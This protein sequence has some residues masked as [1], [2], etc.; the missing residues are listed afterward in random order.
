VFVHDDHQFVIGCLARSGGLARPVLAMTQSYYP[1]PD[2]PHVNIAQAT[3]LSRLMQGAR[4]SWTAQ[5][6]QHKHFHAHDWITHS[7]WNPVFGFL[8]VDL[9]D[10][11]SSLYLPIDASSA[12][13][14]REGAA[15][16]ALI[17]LPLASARRM[18][19]SEYISLGLVEQEYDSGWTHGMPNEAPDREVLAYALQPC[20]G[21]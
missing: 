20:L 13:F 6:L 16:T 14:Y 3:K 5:D 9:N 8:H 1:N 19:T 21:R 4:L 18:L 17:D 12:S 15:F 10:D 11:E 7:G 2:S